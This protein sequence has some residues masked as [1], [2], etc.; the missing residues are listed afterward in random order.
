VRISVADVDGN[1][2]PDI[3]RTSTGIAPNFATTGGNTVYVILTMPATST[4][5]IQ[6][7]SFEYGGAIAPT[8]KV[9]G[10]ENNLLNVDNLWENLTE[11]YQNSSVQYENPFQKVS[12]TTTGQPLANLTLEDALIYNVAKSKMLDV[13]MAPA[14]PSYTTMP[15]TQVTLRAR[16]TTSSDYNGNSVILWSTDHVTWHST[17]IKPT[18][19]QNANVTFDL[20]AAGITTWAQLQNVYI[21]YWNNETTGVNPVQ[22]NYIWL[23]VKFATTRQLEWNYQVPNDVTKSLHN[24]TINAKVLIPGESFNVSYSTDNATFFPLFQITSTTQINYYAMLMDTSN[25]KYYIKIVDN[26]RTAADTFNSTLCVNQ[27]K[28]NHYSPTVTW[29]TS[30]AWQRAVTTFSNNA[31]YITSIAAADIGSS[32]APYKPDGKI[33]I[34]VGTTQIGSG[35]STHALFVITNSGSG[36]QTPI[37]IPMVAA[38]AA[39]GTNQ[40]NINAVVV[41]DF[42]GDGY[43]DIAVAIGFAPGYSYPAGSTSTLWIYYSQPS[44]LGWQFNEQA[45]NVLDSSGSTINIKAGYVDLTLLWPLFGVF[46][47]VVAEAA[48]GRAERMKKK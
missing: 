15:V 22:F 31:Q 21:R 48:I 47:I 42:N 2:Y 27:L 32:V 30:S 37:D 18:A 7:P 46:G 39:I 17:T 12:D 29:T 9:T 6:N 11:V 43:P 24:L 10:S 8:A 34:V 44:G 35:D 23:E 1:G 5:N 33:D 41:G 45:V 26:D 13:V 28:I 3:I 16:Y 14:N 40:Y 36:L 4:S 38:T 19:N 25:S 20:R